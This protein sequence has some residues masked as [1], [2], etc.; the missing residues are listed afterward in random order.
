MKIDGIDLVINVCN[1]H[2]K[3]NIIAKVIGHDTAEDILR[4]VIPF[5]L[6]TN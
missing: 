2:Y 6:S 3:M 1:I 5:S 4:D